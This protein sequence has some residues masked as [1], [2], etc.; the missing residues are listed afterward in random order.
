MPPT[1]MVVV[2]LKMV[3]VALKP[4]PPTKA[5]T[6]VEVAVPLMAG[7]HVPESSILIQPFWHLMPLAWKLRELMH[8]QVP[9]G[10]YLL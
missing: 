4:V 6:L 1:K 10:V 7:M 5:M 3:V 9:S 2:A 8:L